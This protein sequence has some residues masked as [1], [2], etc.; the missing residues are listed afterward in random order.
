MTLGRIPEIDVAEAQRRLTDAS[1]PAPLLIDVRE[2]HEFLHIR[3]EGAA[4]FPLST[5]V[6][7]IGELPKDQPIQIIC[8]TGNRSGNATA[9]LLANGWSDVV[10][11]AGGTMAWARAGFP[12]RRGPTDPGEGDLPG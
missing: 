5:F 10:N 6:A 8:Q 12:T 1:D 4:L 2:P 11:I 9:Y 7:R 3:A